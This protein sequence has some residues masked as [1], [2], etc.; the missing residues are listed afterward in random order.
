[1][2]FKID[3]NVPVEVAED[4]RAAGH[5]ADTVYDEGAAGAP[6][7]SLMI[8]ARADGRVSLTLD[9]GVADIRAYPPEEYAGVVLFRPP[10]TGRGAVLAF[11]RRHLPPLLALDLS[12]H[13]HIVTEGT[14]RRR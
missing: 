9:K 10:T 12:G 5:E 1:V 11:V 7:A 8:R 6:D 3:E 13:L 14:I 4:L 2:K